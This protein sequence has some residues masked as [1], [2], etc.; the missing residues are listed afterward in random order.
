MKQ[1]AVREIHRGAGVAWLIAAAT[2]C[3]FAQGEPGSA[4]NPT[5]VAREQAARLEV[6]ASSLPRFDGLESAAGDTR[7]D[8]TLLPQRRSAVG[9][10]VGMSGFNQGFAPAPGTPAAPLNVDL[11][12]HWRHKVDSTYQ[13]DV[14]AWRRMSQ[15]PEAYLMALQ[16][17]PSY[18]ARV[19][20]NL[21]DVR[22]S[23][24]VAGRG[25]LG[26]Q[27]ESGARISLKRK[28]GASMLYYRAK[29]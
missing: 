10:A 12:V 8:M 23:G 3:A 29:F 18:V 9:L 7:V 13:V 14:T 4:E 6:S 27:L 26:F 22:R 24:L 15:Q 11:G 16:R 28:D 25:F 2:T 1:A 21:G 19:E 17:Q 20:L 5:P